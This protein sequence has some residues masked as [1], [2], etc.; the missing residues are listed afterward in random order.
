[1]EINDDNVLVLRAHREDTREYD[2]SAMFVSERS[3]GKFQRSFQLPPVANRKGKVTC[4]FNNH[5]LE[6]SIPKWDDK[7]KKA[8]CVKIDIK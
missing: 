2:T 3:F 5:Q 1:M 7:G 6:I 8:S 4:S